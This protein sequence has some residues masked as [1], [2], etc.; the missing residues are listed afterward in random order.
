MID[1]SYD[2]RNCDVL[3]PSTEVIKILPTPRPGPNRSVWHKARLVAAR[4]QTGLG[5]LKICLLISRTTPG[6]FK[7]IK[8]SAWLPMKLSLRCMRCERHRYAS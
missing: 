1:T 3:A 2:L 7:L 4:S 5:H 8:H 6:Q